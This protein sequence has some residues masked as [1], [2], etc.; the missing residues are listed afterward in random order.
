MD[1]ELVEFLE[2]LNYGGYARCITGT[3][4]GLAVSACREHFDVTLRGLSLYITSGIS[5]IGLIS[6]G[7]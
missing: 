5:R 6:P 4:Y 2:T 1:T 3:S 7:G